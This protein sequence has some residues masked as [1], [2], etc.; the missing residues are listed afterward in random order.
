[1]GF[2]DRSDSIHINVTSSSPLHKQWIG[3]DRKYLLHALNLAGMWF[4]N[5][6]FE[7][8]NVDVIFSFYLY[9]L[10]IFGIL[11]FLQQIA[12]TQQRPITWNDWQHYGKTYERI[13]IKFSGWVECG[14]RNNMK[15]FWWCCIQSLWYRIFSFF[16]GNSCPLITLWKHQGTG[17]H[18][19]FQDN[20]DIAQGTSS[21]FWV[22]LFTSG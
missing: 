8:H 15:H 4:Y 7:I 11:Y 2:N 14:T 5:E 9:Q 18:K 1:M 6:K 13:F 17:F 3:H 16:G 21:I 20:S 12:F 19:N 22:G 10:W